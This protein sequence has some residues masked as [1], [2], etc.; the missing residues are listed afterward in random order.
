MELNEYQKEAGKTAI[1]PESYKIIYPALG[2][3]GETGEVCEKIKKAVRDDNGVFTEDKIREITK[4]LG[5]V[6]WY[7]AAIAHDLNLDLETIAQ[8]NLDKLRSRA[9]RDKIHGNGDNR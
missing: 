4:E 1:Y 6:M 7:I 5:D 3:A 8:G 2:L 9:D